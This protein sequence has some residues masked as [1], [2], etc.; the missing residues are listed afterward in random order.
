MLMNDWFN[1]NIYIEDEK[2]FL[3]LKNISI[4]KLPQVGICVYFHMSH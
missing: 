4:N 3:L 2:T 1:I